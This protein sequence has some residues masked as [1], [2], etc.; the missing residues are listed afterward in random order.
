MLYIDRCY[1]KQKQGVFVFECFLMMMMIVCEFICLSLGTPPPN[2]THSSETPR[3]ADIRV[4][5][6][7]YKILPILYY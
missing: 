4:Y 1:D 3:S 7:P 2:T 5:L 6:G